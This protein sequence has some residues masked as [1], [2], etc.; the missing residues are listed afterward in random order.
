MFARVA[1][2]TAVLVLLPRCTFSHHAT[3]ASELG[4]QSSSDALVALLETPGPVELETVVSAD[5]AVERKGLVNLDHPRA[6]EAGLKNG[7]EPI[8]I[9]FH[10]LRHPTRGLFIVDTGVEKALRTAPDK[11]AIRGLVASVMKTDKMR[12]PN[13]LGTWLSQQKEPLK[14]VLLTHLHLDHVS[15]MPDVPR[16]TPIYAGPGETRSTEL[17][18][19][20]VRPNIDR[21]LEGHAAIREWQYAADPQGRFA[22]V[23]DIFGD[24]SVWA[25]WVPGHTPGSTAYLVRSTRGPVLL[26]GDASHTAWGWEHDVEPGTFTHDNPTSVKSFANL[27]RFAAAHPAVEVRL[28]HQDLPP[29]SAQR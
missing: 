5:W 17:L 25:L 21:A 1:L 29:A 19:A 20:V 27:R 4:K 16:G 26:T 7:E 28:G 22:G 2:L 13:D 9:Y 6:K 14:G 18:N 12:F 3:V 11:A 15:G 10:A 24:G 8:H 23:V